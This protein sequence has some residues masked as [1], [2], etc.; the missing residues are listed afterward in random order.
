MRDKNKIYWDNLPFNSVRAIG[1][2]REYP[3]KKSAKISIMNAG[4]FLCPK[5]PVI[6]CLDDYPLPAF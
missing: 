5:E 3:S 6:Y 4:E 1:P 2:G